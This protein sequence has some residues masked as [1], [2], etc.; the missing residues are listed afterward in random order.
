MGVPHHGVESA[1]YSN[2]TI[3]YQPV[4]ICICGYHTDYG[5]G[6]WERAG[7]DFDQH[8]VDVRDEI[9]AADAED[10]AEKGS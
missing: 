6:S 8:L 2:G 9:T 3:G 10:A 5:N 4:M 7:A 1:H